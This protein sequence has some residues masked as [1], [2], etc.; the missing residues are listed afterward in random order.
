[1]G[2]HQFK[3]GLESVAKVNWR[4]RTVLDV[5]CGDGNLTQAILTKTRCKRIIGIDIDEDKIKRAKN[6]LSKEG[7][8]KMAFFVADASNL[9]LF[10]DSSFDAVFSNIAFHQFADKKASLKEIFRVLRIGGEAIINFIEEKSEVRKQMEKIASYA[11]FDKFVKIGKGKGKKISKE[12][13]NKIARDVGFSKV[14]SVSKDH[15]FWYPTVESLLAGYHNLDVTFP[16]LKKLPIKLQDL[17][18]EKLRQEFL[19]RKTTKGFGE[20]W[21]VVFAHL[22]K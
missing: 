20:T 4:N 3:I 17:L 18:W 13:F 22:V 1:M 11:P 8:S 21:R 14:I 7:V 16:E 9:D 12:E 6:R 5:G 10:K 19:S 2:V 15:T